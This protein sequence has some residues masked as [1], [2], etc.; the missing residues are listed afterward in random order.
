MPWVKLDD[1]MPEHP[2][3]AQ[4]GPLALAM[5]VAALCYSNRKL[6][7]GFIPRSI[8]RT[9]LDWE[10][11]DDEG[12]VQTLGIT[13][14][15]V[16]DDVTADWVIDRLVGVG[17]WEEAPGGFQIHDFDDYQ[18][19]KSDVEREREAARKR[20][21]DLRAHRTGSSAEVQ[22]NTSG[23][24]KALPSG[25]QANTERSSTTPVPV[26]VPVPQS[27]VEVSSGERD[28]R[29]ASSSSP[30]GSVAEREPNPWYD[31]AAIAL[32][33]PPNG[34]D[35]TL[36]GM[37][38]AKAQSQGHPP[39]EILRRVAAHLAV[40]NFACTPGSVH[41]RWDQ[42]GSRVTTATTAE[43]ARIGA[44]MGRIRAR[45]EFLAGGGT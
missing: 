42:L 5:Q 38:A 30:N 8:A 45:K 23:D 18:P 29:G 7:D 43:R 16:G 1:Q 10:M 3:V 25:V 13:S 22:A 12:R 34:S 27:E 4:A 24:Q 14:G 36:L 41:K 37:I 32:D 44:E 6:T 17:M 2:K 33:V 19:S 9:L 21:A 11:V 31:A 35:Q 28:S 40:F 26:P 20:M 39:E 15:Y